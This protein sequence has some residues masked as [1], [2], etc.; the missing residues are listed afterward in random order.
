MINKVAR[1]RIIIIHGWEGS[2]REGWFPWLARELTARGFSV[3]VP[4]MPNSAH[5]KIAEWV[6]H[7]AQTV[8]TADEH[9]FL[10]G[11]S[12]G[13]ITIL[14]Y[15]EQLPEEQTIGGAVLVAG[16][17]ERLSYDELQN[18]FSQPVNWPRV[19]TTCPKFV[20]LFSDNDQY[21][22]ISNADLFRR[23]LS[24]EVAVLQN[25][26]HFSGEDDSCTDLPEAL[27]AVLKLIDTTQI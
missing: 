19:R 22:P 8:G 27:E 10:V 21:V 2:P 24:A 23:E 3:V 9:T 6:P 18:F 26:G 7:L 12:L 15:L 20:A 16:F 4:A 13:C 14:R 25:R 11:H 17:G 1:P 5:P